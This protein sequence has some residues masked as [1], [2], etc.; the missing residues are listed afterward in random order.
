MSRRQVFEGGDGA[1]ADGADL[2]VGG[3]DLAHAV[4][5][6]AAVERDSDRTAGTAVRL[7]GEG[8]HGGVGHGLDDAVG[9]G[10]FDVVDRSSPPASYRARH[11]IT[12]CRVTPTCRPISVLDMPSAASNTIRACCT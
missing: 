5:Q 11:E 9:A 8:R 4:G 12:V 10:G 6:V 3:V 1:F 2:G 7:V